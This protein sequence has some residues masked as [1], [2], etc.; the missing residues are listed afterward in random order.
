MA[1]II[2]GPPEDGAPKPPLGKRILWFAALWLGG[3]VVVAAAAY[4]LRALILPS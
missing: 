3:L 2:E 4:G 1:P